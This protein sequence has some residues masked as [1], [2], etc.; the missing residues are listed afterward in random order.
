MGTPP[1]V[2]VHFTTVADAGALV[3]RLASDA[4]PGILLTGT[5][6]T[7]RAV[8]RAVPARVRAVNIGGIHHREDRTQRLRY[9][10]LNADEERELRSLEESG[11][12]VTAQDVPSARPVPLAEVL[13]GEGA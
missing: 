3:E 5:I 4:R 7:M 6:E 13:R 8:V 2:D 1:N 12:V 9:V 10:F 11:V